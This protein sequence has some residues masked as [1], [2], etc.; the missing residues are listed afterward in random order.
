[1]TPLRH[2]LDKRL[3]AAPRTAILT[4]VQHRAHFGKET[5]MS[6]TVNRLS[7]TSN[8][9]HEA[10]DADLPIQLELFVEDAEIIRALAEYPEGEPRNQYA[11]EAMKI[12]ILA[13]RH[14]GG[15]VGADTIRRENDRLVASV[16]KTFDQYTNTVQDRIEIKLKEYFDPKD[17]RFTDR[18]QRLLAQDGELSQLLKGFVDGENS[19]FAR[20]LVTHVGRESALMKVLDPQQSDGLLTTLRKNVDDQLTRQRDHLLNEFSLDNKDG[21]LS[22]LLSELTVNH[23]DVGK[24]LQTKIDTVI[25]E[26][27]LNE[28]NSALSRLVHNVNNA[29]RTITNE[30]SLD[31][32]ASCLSK[33]KRELVEQLAT[34]E[35]KNQQFQEEVKI[36]LAKIVTQREEAERSTRHG[37]AFEDAVCNFLVRQSQHAGDVATLAGSQTGLIKN[38]KVGDC[39]IELGPDSAAPGSK[40]VVEAKEKEGYS[41]T[42]AREEIEIA[43]KNR[44]A[45]WGIFVF[46]KKTAPANLEPFSRYGNDFIVVWDAEDISTDVF[47]KAGVIAARALCFRAERRS[48][49]EK[50][51]FEV[52]DKAILDIEKRTSNLDDVRKSAETIQSSSTKIL[53]R[54]RIDREALEKQLEILREKVKDLRELTAATQ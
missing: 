24:A 27:S 25:K 19:L 46:S 37:I 12:G 41:L 11:I 53:E 28:E 50:V 35:K 5:R 31:N 43:R 9:R 14:V 47:L 40:I 2:F 32:D 7:T 8:D 38:S 29:Q 42:N 34:S 10:F 6:A 54:V 36:S 13:L 45:D 16:Q 15:Q 49:A 22:R 3:P 51:D 18:V 20:T 23:G 21:A 52:I 4:P 33:L 1:M 30:F 48:A 26:F 39:V 17:G 44:G